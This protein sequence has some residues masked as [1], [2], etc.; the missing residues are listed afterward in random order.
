L[1]SLS[2]GFGNGSYLLSDQGEI[3]PV[4]RVF[5]YEAE[6]PCWVRF[7][8]DGT[9][10]WFSNL[11]SSSVSLYKVNP[12][13]ELSF[14]SRNNTVALGLL[15]SDIAL[16]SAGKYLYQSKPLPVSPKINVLRVLPLTDETQNGGLKE[17]ETVDVPADSNP[18]GL[19]VVDL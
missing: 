6:D 17:V 12:Q 14:V 4:S 11:F 5:E 19:V 18:I 1:A 9:Y 15:S 2:T 3:S 10:A 8:K 7:R 16:D 13:G